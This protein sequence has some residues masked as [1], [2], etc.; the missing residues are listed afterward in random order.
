M[1]LCRHTGP[2]AGI[3]QTTERDTYAVLA[4]NIEPLDPGSLN[5]SGM[6]QGGAMHLYRHTGHRV[7]IQ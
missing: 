2:R 6:T 1:H 7:G 3:Q 4:A 5:A